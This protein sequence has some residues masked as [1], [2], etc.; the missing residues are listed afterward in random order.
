MITFLNKIREIGGGF[1]VKKN[2]IEF[3]YEQPFEAG[4]ISKQMSIPAS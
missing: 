4:S 3:F 2:G 1:H